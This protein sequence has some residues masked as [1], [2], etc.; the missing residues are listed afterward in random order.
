MLNFGL[1]GKRYR[2]YKGRKWYERAEFSLERYA[3]CA[4]VNAATVGMELCYFK[5][6]ELQ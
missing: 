1:L 4:A 3:I 5:V 6:E 2:V